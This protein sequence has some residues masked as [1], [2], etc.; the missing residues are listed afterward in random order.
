MSFVY[1]IADQAKGT[2]KIG[3]AADVAARLVALQVGNAHHLTIAAVV[4]GDAR[5]ES[6]LH[7]TFRE[8]HI[9]GEWFRLDGRLRE[10]V[11]LL[12]QWEHAPPR[13]RRTKPEQPSVRLTEEEKRSVRDHWIAHLALLRAAVV[14]YGIDKFAALVGSRRGIVASALYENG[15]VRFAA[16]WWH[17]LREVTTP[18]HIKRIVEHQASLVD[19]VIPTQPRPRP[20]VC[21]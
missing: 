9:R 6:A 2:V 10:F 8:N 20:E 13:V 5:Y 14:D 4:P 12:P 21:S 16:K 15:R 11:D 7:S 19:L 1:F 3:H 17:A 18:E